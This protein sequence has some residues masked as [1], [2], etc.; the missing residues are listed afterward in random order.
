MQVGFVVAERVLYMPS[1]G[2]CMALS[3]GFDAIL[4]SASP[5]KNKNKEVHGSEDAA[6]A[7]HVSRAGM[8]W[9]RCARA[10]VVVFFFARTWVRNQD[11]ATREGFY[12]AILRAAPN[13]P[14]AHYGY[15]NV[16]INDPKRFEVSVRACVRTYVFFVCVCVCV[17]VVIHV[18]GYE[19]TCIHTNI[20]T[21]IDR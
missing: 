13:N 15:G 2:Y 9:V 11:W 7:S 19:C 5:A 10:A 18:Y 8:R 20:C 12:A 1:L 14:K 21:D 6:A 4:A 3:L 17:C 16:V